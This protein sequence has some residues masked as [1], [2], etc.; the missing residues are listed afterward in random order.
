MPRLREGPRCLHDG[1]G[2]AETLA[3]LAAGVGQG[4]FT[5]TH[6]VAALDAFAARDSRVG[7]WLKG[8][9]PA[10]MQAGP[11]GASG[12]VV[13]R[14]RDFDG[15]PCGVALWCRKPVELL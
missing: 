1:I 2:G 5:L 9:R 12:A 15:R 7:E 11:V 10:D 8:V 4:P 3:G 14:P 13:C 6:G